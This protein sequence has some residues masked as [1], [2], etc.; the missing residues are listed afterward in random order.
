L[1][2]AN[3]EHGHH[4]VEP[5]WQ[6]HHSFLSQLFATDP[7]ESTAEAID[8]WHYWVPEGYSF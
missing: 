6:G 5:L 7:D 2:K 8:N 3:I 1:V 4:H